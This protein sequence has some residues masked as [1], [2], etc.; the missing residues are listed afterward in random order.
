MMLKTHHCGNLSKAN[1]GE[2]VVLNGWVSVRRD[3]G[4]GTGTVV[5]LS[6]EDGDPVEAATSAGS[7][8]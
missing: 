3:L 4:A 5:T 6:V 2:T 7:E 1:V 8:K